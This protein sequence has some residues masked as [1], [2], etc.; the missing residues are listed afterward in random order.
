MLHPVVPGVGDV[1]RSIRRHRHAPRL[2]EGAAGGLRLRR[3]CEAA[4]HLQDGAVRSQM[5]DAMVEGV[6]HVQ[7]AIGGDGDAA[8]RIEQP[9]SAPAASTIG[10]AGSWIMPLAYGSSIA[11]G[12]SAAAVTP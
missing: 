4:P 3:I 12:S 7:A 1:D 5:L 8:R 9:G 10:C 6:G 2:I 11:V